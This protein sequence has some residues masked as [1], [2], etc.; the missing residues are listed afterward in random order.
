[1]RQYVLEAYE[2]GYLDGLR[3]A[4]AELVNGSRS[5]AGE[6]EERNQ[7][8][9]RCHPVYREGFSEGLRDGT[10]VLI[11]IG[12]TPRVRTGQI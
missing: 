2:Q 7:T 6:A 9:V 8:E 3:Q 12:K 1:M 4:H 5:D 11:E 10:E